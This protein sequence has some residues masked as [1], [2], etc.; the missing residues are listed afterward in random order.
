MIIH[1]DIA[2]DDFGSNPM[3]SV[4]IGTKIPPPPT[5]PTLP[6]AAPKNP[7]NDPSTICHPNS[8]SGQTCWYEL[9]SLFHIRLATFFSTLISSSGATAAP[10]SDSESPRSAATAAAADAN[11][12][13]MAATACHLLPIARPQQ[14]KP[15]TSLLPKNQKRKFKKDS[16]MDFCALV[17]EP[18]ESRD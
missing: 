11:A 6:N 18:W 15:C 7:I 4:S 14:G 13:P 5:P 3:I 10:A 1:F 9:P 2:V 17:R 8:I 12:T 16:K